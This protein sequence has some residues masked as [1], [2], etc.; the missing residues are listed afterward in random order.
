MNSTA[1]AIVKPDELETIQRTGRLLANSGYFDGK[2]DTPQAIAMMA[3]KILAGRE[4]GIGPFASVNGIHIV[5]G[6]PTIGANL[7]AAAVRSH[8]RYDYRVK[9]LSDK[10]CEL[11]FLD[12]GKP[13]G[14][15]RFTVEDAAKAELTTGQNSHTWKKYARNMLFA[16]AMSNGVR[17]YAPDIFSGNV[18]YLPEELDVPVDGDGNIVDVTPRVV[19]QPPRQEPPPTRPVPTPQADTSVDADVLFG[20]DDQAEQ[21]DAPTD[22]ENAIIAMWQSPEDAKVWAVNTGACENEHEAKN[23]FKK[24][25]DAHGGRLNKSNVAAVYLDFLRRQNEKLEAQAELA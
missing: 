8:P 19:E 7:M 22:E 14:T 12:N 9:E 15:S 3:T 10:V 25:V 2:G 21:N 18:V 11:E 17:W 24:I 16:R 6:K 13:A 20:T 23:S 5:H 4:I 1:L